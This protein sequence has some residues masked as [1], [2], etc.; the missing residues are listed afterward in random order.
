MSDY[1]VSNSKKDILINQK[2]L[3]IMLLYSIIFPLILI[4]DGD[5]KYL[6]MSFLL[7]FINVNFCR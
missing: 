2:Y 5:N 4:V 6:M 7:P 3:L 1:Y